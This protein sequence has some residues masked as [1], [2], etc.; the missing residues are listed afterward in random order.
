MW[1]YL[2]QISLHFLTFKETF[3]IFRNRQS[4]NATLKTNKQTKSQHKPKSEM[5]LQS[6][7]KVRSCTRHVLKICDFSILQPFY[8]KDSFHNANVVLNKK[9]NIVRILLH[10]L[11]GT[12]TG[13]SDTDTDTGTDRSK[14]HHILIL[15]SFLSEITA[16][17]IECW[18][19]QWEL[20][21][22]HRIT[23]FFS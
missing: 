20:S 21:S 11:L 16:L 5:Y 8:T 9:Q 6:S 3:F 10:F 4:K 14:D 23:Y 19:L 1:S 12:F 15:L 22:F 2:T 7:L 17:K 18:W 13:I